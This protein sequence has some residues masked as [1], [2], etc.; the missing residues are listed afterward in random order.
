VLVGSDG[1][2]IGS[3]AFRRLSGTDGGHNGVAGKGGIVVT[4]TTELSVLSGKG[5]ASGTT[6]SVS[7]HSSVD[8]LDSTNGERQSAAEGGGRNSEAEARTSPGRSTSRSASRNGKQS[9]TGQHV[10]NG[11][12]STRVVA[13]GTEQWAGGGPPVP[14][15]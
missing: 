11:D 3:N 4:T 14:L 12:G 6:S 9:S 2:A 5:G 13:F 8:G 15:K 10:L 1:H 7:T